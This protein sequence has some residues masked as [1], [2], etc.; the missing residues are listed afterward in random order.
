MRKP[1]VP[2]VLQSIISGPCND[3][4]PRR[5]DIVAASIG[6]GLRV[7]RRV[8][9]ARE[10]LLERVSAEFAEMPGLTL[11]LPQA[12]RLF[13]LRQDICQRVMASL[14]ERKVLR[15]TGHRAYARE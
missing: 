6:E 13:A 14:V 8:P 10:R 3:P 12:M 4:R 11:T 1:S 2:S 9:G 7:E 15:E 5:W